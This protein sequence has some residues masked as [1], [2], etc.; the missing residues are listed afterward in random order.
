MST[1]AGDERRRLGYPACVLDRRSPSPCRAPHRALAV[2]TALLVAGA[3]ATLVGCADG[4]VV[5]R[6]TLHVPAEL[7]AREF[8]VVTV[9]DDAGSDAVSIADA[10]AASITARGP[11]R[12]LRGGAELAASDR[13]DLRVHV[14]D[15]QTRSVADAELVEPDLDCTGPGPESCH[16][17]LTRSGV[18]GATLEE[19]VVLDLYVRGGAA[20]RASRIV[21]VRVTA[22]ESDVESRVREALLES[23]R[24]L[25]EE[26]DLEVMVDLLPVADAIA[27][28]AIEA[29]ARREFDAA[30]SYFAML[31][32]DP[33]FAA[34]SPQE[35]ARLLY[36]LGQLWRVAALDGD[37]D[38]EPQ[39]VA[40]LL[41]ASELVTDPRIE[42]A[43]DA[44]ERERAA[45][46]A[47]RRWSE[48]A[49]ATP[50]EP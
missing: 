19:S 8:A 1:A 31:V 6:A 50:S 24:G 4:T 49:S 48:A 37:P 26:F 39:A 34:R 17:R 28:A 32:D 7:P 5:Y 43:L 3:V 36:N 46:E 22:S 42:R 47:R 38:G 40:A 21:E 25:L 30:R 11:G 18:S 14:R 10:L 33:S 16:A 35:R 27:V 45:R 12:A 23:V 44:V 20:P 13:S 15:V 2:G 29:A 41:H 9:T